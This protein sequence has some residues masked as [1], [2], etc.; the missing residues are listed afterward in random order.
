MKLFNILVLT[1]AVIAGKNDG[2]N[3][4]VPAGKHLNNEE[5]N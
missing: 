4:D 1:S 3:E 2:R 5:L